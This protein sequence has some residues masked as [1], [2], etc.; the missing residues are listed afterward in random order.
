MTTDEKELT[1]HFL[2]ALIEEM[3]TAGSNDFD[4]K[5]FIEDR[6]ERDKFVAAFRKLN[7][8]PPQDGLKTD[9]GPD[10]RLPDFCVVTLLVDKLTKELHA[11][12]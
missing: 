8:D 10:M 6:E 3:G 2:E 12:S 11:A 5:Q 9:D 7:G 4:L 1:I